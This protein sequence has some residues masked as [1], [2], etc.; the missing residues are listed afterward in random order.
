M[1]VDEMI[2]EVC[3]PISYNNTDTKHIT[4]VLRWLNRAQEDMADFDW[5]ELVTANASFITTTS[6]TYDLTGAGYAGST[7]QRVVDKTVRIDDQNLS[8]RQK[9]WFD[10]LDPQRTMSGYTK[11]YGMINRKDFRIYPSPGAGKTCYYDWVKTPAAL[12]SGGAESSC[13]FYPDRH[14]Y[15]VSGAIWRGLRFIGDTDTERREMMWRELIERKFRKT[16]L[17]RKSRHFITPNKF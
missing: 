16:G 1:T 17:A 4:R 6:E 10:E 9:S 15:I 11:Y 8:Y 3:G 2:A 5:P 13:S 7:F 14:D 12:A